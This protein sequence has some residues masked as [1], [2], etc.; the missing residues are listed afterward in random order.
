MLRELRKIAM[1]TS[2]FDI[3][4]LGIKTQVGS[5]QKKSSVGS[6]Q[7]EVVSWQSSVGRKKKKKWAV[8]SR[9]LAVGGGKQPGRLKCE[10]R[11]LK[12]EN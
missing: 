6:G 5:W 11:S 8:G 12:F 2:L 10:V 4:W 3:F 7:K 9:Q 1:R